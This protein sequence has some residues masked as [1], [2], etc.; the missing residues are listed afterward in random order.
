MVKTEF[1]PHL[2]FFNVLN[3]SN[4]EYAIY[5]IENP[6]NI[7][8]FKL[9]QDSKMLCLTTNNFLSLSLLYAKNS[10]TTSTYSGDIEGETITI[11]PSR[12]D[13]NEMSSEVDFRHIF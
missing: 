1:M 12:F 11:S 5:K 7:Y 10:S 8:R 3:I 6:S 2:W 4:F 13:K 9:V